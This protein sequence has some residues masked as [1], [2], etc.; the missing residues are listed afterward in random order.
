MYE[1]LEIFKEKC[2]VESEMSF[3]FPSVQSTRSTTR[4]STQDVMTVLLAYDHQRGRLGGSNPVPVRVCSE[5]ENGRPW[6]WSAS[7][8]RGE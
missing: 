3:D 1:I 2:L 8:Q 4:D 7:Q 5:E 6:Q